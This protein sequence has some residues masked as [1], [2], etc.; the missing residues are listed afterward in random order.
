MRT[1]LIEKT[2]MEGGQGGFHDLKLEVYKSGKPDKAKPAWREEPSEQQ[3]GEGENLKNRGKRE[4]SG[5]LVQRGGYSMMMFLSERSSR[6]SLQKG[7]WR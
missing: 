6:R 7:G 4:G 5:D 3:R 1:I 2:S